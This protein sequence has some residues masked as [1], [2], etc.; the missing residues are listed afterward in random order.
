M[1]KQELINELNYIENVY[2]HNLKDEI[3]SGVTEF[4]ELKGKKSNFYFNFTISEID[5]KNQKRGMGR[6][7]KKDNK[8]IVTILESTYNY[9]TKKETILY[10]WRH[11]IKKTHDEL[12]LENNKGIFTTNY[13]VSGRL[14]EKIIIPATHTI[15]ELVEKPNVYEL[16]DI[17][18]K[19][20]TKSLK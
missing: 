9:E 20:K 18:R 1:D 7:I 4:K 10:L 16:F 19:T 17:N 5:F 14:V 3:P 12:I 11:Q 2:V 15:D 13:Y 6:F 8:I